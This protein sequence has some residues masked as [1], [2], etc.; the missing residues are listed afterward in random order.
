R[1]A[2]WRHQ[3]LD[4]RLSRARPCLKNRTYSLTCSEFQARGKVESVAFDGVADIEV[5]D[6]AR[7]KVEVAFANRSR[8]RGDRADAEGTPD[9]PI[10]PVSKRSLIICDLLDPAL[11]KAYSEPVLESF[12]CQH[13]QVGLDTT[14]IMRSRILSVEIHVPDSGQLQVD[15]WYD[16]GVS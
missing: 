1:A 2:P 3:S 10:E 14:L 8:V 6:P 15:F 9:K 12:N 13:F 7:I 4:C 11:N 5:V 16:L